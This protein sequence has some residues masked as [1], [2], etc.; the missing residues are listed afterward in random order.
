M[1]WNKPT[2]PGRLPIALLTACV[3]LA[4]CGQ[5]GPL[6]IPP[7]PPAPPADVD[8]HHVDTAPVDNNDDN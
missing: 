2:Q 5:K 7:E 6:F 3:L 8:T 1:P 4:G